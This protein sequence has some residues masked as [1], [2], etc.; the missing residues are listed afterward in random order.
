M[1]TK[2][3]QAMALLKAVSDRS[4]YKNKDQ[5]LHYQWVLGFVA[6]ALNDALANDIR[7][8]NQFKQKLR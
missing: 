7:L 4:P 8:L 2:Q 5:R 6:G 1:N 3:T